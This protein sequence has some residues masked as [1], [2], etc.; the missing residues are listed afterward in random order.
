MGRRRVV[1]KFSLQRCDELGDIWLS[2]GAALRDA[3]ETLHVQGLV[4]SENRAQD[5]ILHW[6]DNARLCA[7]RYLAAPR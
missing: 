7:V 4:S 2:L 5:N 3:T 1:N 6:V